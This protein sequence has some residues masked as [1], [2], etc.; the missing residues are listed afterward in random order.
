MPAELLPYLTA[1]SL[2]AAAGFAWWALKMSWAAAKRDAM[3][4]GL[5]TAL[6]ELRRRVDEHD[7]LRE[8]MAR[9]EQAVH[10]MRGSLQRIESALHT[11][12]A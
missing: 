11:R 5:K 8:R 2:T 7:D 12:T 6:D 4:D 1:G 9:L 3:L 10:D